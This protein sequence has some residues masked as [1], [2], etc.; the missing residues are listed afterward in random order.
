M[1]R[2]W[3]QSKTGQGESW[4]TDNISGWKTITEASTCGGRRMERKRRVPGTLREKT[5]ES[6]DLEGR[7]AEGA[8]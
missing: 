2:G 5:C 4:K 1:R 8:I 7:R 6:L 3:T